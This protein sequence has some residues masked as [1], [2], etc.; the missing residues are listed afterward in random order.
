MVQPIQQRFMPPMQPTS[1]MWQK[2][3]E[4]QEAGLD[5]ATTKQ[6]AAAAAAGRYNPMLPRNNLIAQTLHM[7]AVSMNGGTYLIDRAFDTL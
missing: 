4:E 7:Q 2:L 3:V 1:M 5:D 6:Q